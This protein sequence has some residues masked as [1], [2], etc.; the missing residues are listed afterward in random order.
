MTGLPVVQ[1]A[2]APGSLPRVA[3]GLHTRI[4]SA[5]GMAL[6]KPTT[7][8]AFEALAARTAFASFFKHYLFSIRYGDSILGSFWVRFFHSYVFST[9]SPLRF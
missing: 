7:G 1:S 4:E 3:Q 6:E 5:C 8:D 9:T 2:A